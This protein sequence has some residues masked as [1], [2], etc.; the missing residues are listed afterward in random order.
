VSPELTAGTRYDTPQMAH[1][2]SE[3]HA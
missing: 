2:D 3:G 1:L